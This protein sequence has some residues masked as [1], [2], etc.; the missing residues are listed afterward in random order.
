MHRH[1][2]SLL[3]FWFTFFV[4]GSLRLTA[5]DRQTKDTVYE[6]A[7]MIIS[8][9][10]AR[11]RETP[12]TFSNLVPG[13]I[14]DRYSMQDVPVL[15]S[16]LPSVT[17]Y[18]ENGN[19]I[20]YNYINLRGFDQR[21]ISVM[22]NGVPQNDPEDHNVYWIDFPD[23]LASAGTLQV[24]R[25]GGSAFYGPPAIGGSV[26]LVTDPFSMEP[27]ITLESDFGF[28]QFGDSSRSLPLASKKLGTTFSSGLVQ[29]HYMFYGHLGQITSN[30]Y[31]TNSWVD[32]D[33]Y[34]FGALRID[35]TM[36][37]RIHFFG[38]P[39]QDGL[40]YT[41]LPKSAGSN[42]QLRRQ[43]LA[44]WTVDSLNQYTSVTPRRSQESESF[45]QPHVEILNEW[46]IS[47]LVTLSNTI[48]FYEGDGYYDY[49][50]SWADTSMLRLGSAYG[51]PATVNPTNALVRAFVG[52]RQWGWLPHAE[53]KSDRSDL[54]IGAEMRFHR[55]THWGKIEFAENLPVGID[56]DY[57][58][59]EYNGVRDIYSVFANEEYH[60]NGDLSF[61]GSLQLVHNLYGI[62]NEKFLAHDFDIS[63]TFVN[64]RLGASF[65]I[66]QQSNIYLSLSYTMREPTMRNLYAAEDS[67]FGATP[68]FQADTTGGVVRYN[69]SRPLAKPERLFD[70]EAG[71]RYETPEFI[72]SFDAY[73]M[74][75]SDEL[76]E[77]GQVDIFGQPVT[78]NA[79]RTRHAGMELEGV[80]KLPYNLSLGGNA[81]LSFNR[82]VSYSV[83]DENGNRVSLD[84]NPI[85]GFPDQLLNVRLTYHDSSLTGS[86]VLK[87]VGS[88]YTDNFKNPQNRNDAYTVWNAEVL[89][90]LPSVLGVAMELRGEVRNIFNSLYF[91]SGQG[92]AFFPA[93]ERNY[94]L[95]AK[96]RL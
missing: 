19:G 52:N 20:G 16:E 48:F 73:L 42:L 70:I 95:G 60:P 62:K 30:G 49:D 74:E 47:P 94:V 78:G 27:G 71:V 85:A 53:I 8:A 92:N 40:A 22:V 39:L 66:S 58:F 2:F 31:R 13:Q 43:N 25:G 44:S 10:Q 63:Y 46:R 75:F 91:M 84:G 82:L 56:P 32:L 86:L 72:G 59:Y 6:L 51:I 7:P 21:R 18:S 5:Q 38:G 11:G 87:E 83:I 68:Q 3:L 79:D 37:T 41:G 24:Q 4:A 26:N 67:Y 54:T 36:T 64:P 65:A 17:T 50:A 55:S 14:N 88:F 9:T 23:L 90:R 61:M 29:D 28:Q 69:Y 80:V 45:S 96:V 34:F 15:L 77:S 1:R 76:I 93:A 89:Y 33:S 81:T 57:H 12:V 35:P